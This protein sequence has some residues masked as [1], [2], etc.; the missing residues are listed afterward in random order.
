MCV[1]IHTHTYTNHSDF[2]LCKEWRG[3]ETGFFIFLSFLNHEKLRRSG[4]GSQYDSSRKVAH[5]PWMLHPLRKKEFP[6][7][8]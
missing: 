4:R 8:L 1:Y 3:V 5:Q 7:A 2:S 6:T